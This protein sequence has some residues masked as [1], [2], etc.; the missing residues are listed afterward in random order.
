MAKDL[1]PRNILKLDEAVVNRIA[2]GEVIQRPANALKELLENSLDA[3]SKSIQITVKDGGLKLLKIQD[4]GSG[5]NKEDLSIVC[6]RFTTSKLQK[7]EDLTAIGTFGFRGEALAS[8]SHVAHL[9]I[10]TKTASMPCA[11]KCS[12][13][14]GKL[15]GTPKPCAGTQG[16]QIIV[17]DLFYNVPTRKGALKSASEEHNRIT[18]V[19]TRFAVHNAPVGFCLRKLNDHGTDIRTPPNS[20]QVDNIRM[21]YTNAVAKDL[22]QLEV[23]EP[24]YKVK[25]NGWIS[26]LDYSGSKFVMLLFINHRLV[27]STLLKKAI[28]SVYSTYLAK[29]KHPFVY[30]SMDIAPIFVDVNVH[31]TKHEV[32][33]LH[34]DTII[35]KIQSAIDILLKGASTS[36]SFTVQT[37][38]PGNPLMDK[39]EKLSNAKLYDK[40]LVRT[41][42]RNQKIDKF[43]SST[44]DDSFDQMGRANES[45]DESLNQTFDWAKQPSKETTKPKF[46]SNEPVK[47]PFKTP[48]TNQRSAES[49]ASNSNNP[50]PN[51]QTG[52]SAERR[53]FDLTS[54]THL[55][56]QVQT[57]SD[58]ILRETFHDST[59]IGCVNKKNALIQH[60]TKLYIIN[61]DRIAEEFFYQTLLN[62]FGNCGVI[63]LSDPPLLQDLALLAMDKKENGWRPEDGPKEQLASQVAEMLS[64][65]REMIEDYF[66]LLINEEKRLLGIPLL[67]VDYIPDLSQLPTWILRLATETDWN[68]EKTCFDTFCRVTCNFYKRPND[69]EI[70]NLGSDKDWKWTVEHVLFPAIK[71]SLLPPK[72]WVQNGTILQIADL[73][74]LYK[75]FERC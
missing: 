31:P 45:M 48:A 54:L 40:D 26:N 7:F 41:D 65:K 37:V 30:L 21:L 6:E 16:T 71:A 28:D 19:V 29:G 75:V 66:S 47:E 25:A 4:D 56:N 72:A 14:D 50:K 74:D 15:V 68:S 35:H 13:S 9:T 62:E 55:R 53:H 63:N 18:E 69:H 49:A 5:I 52:N 46:R 34:E 20:T 39:T 58:K 64:C 23:D 17:E 10:I 42:S 38:L 60:Q 1:K 67:L 33:F 70:L 59:F 43:L 8:I 51:K 27:E 22:V 32:H 57:N 36:K 3:G 73:P 44:L 2:A 61:M 11:Y 24:S 12:Y